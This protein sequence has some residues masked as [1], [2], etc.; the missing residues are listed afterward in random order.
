VKHEKSE[1]FAYPS[2]TLDTPTAKIKADLVR[3]TILDAL[4]L[5]DQDNGIKFMSILIVEWARRFNSDDF[6]QMVHDLGHSP[7]KESVA[8]ESY[9]IVSALWFMDMMFQLA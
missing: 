6:L 7:S 5:L 2:V 9:V 4:E 1:R 8:D 3:R